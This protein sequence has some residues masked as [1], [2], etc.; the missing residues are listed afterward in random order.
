LTWGEHRMLGR[1]LVI[2]TMHHK[3]KVIGPVLTRELGVQV[4]VPRGFDTDRFGTFTREVPR[5][6]DQVSAARTKLSAALRVTG[7][8]LGIASEGS[9]A[10]HP[11]VA[12]IPMNTELLLLL[13]LAHGHE[14]RGWY[15]T[16]HTNMRAQEIATV[17]QALAFAER[18]GFPQHGVIVRRGPDDPV[19]IAKDVRETR[20]LRA[21][22]ANVLGRDPA[23]SAYIET[24]MRAHRNPTRQSAIRKA[25]DDL[26]NNLRSHCPAC[27]APGFSP[28]SVERGLPCSW[29]ATATHLPVAQHWTCRTCS[30]GLTRPVAEDDERADPQHCYRCNP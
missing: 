10:P 7:C 23:R 6:G 12:F 21:V 13:D 22:V 4:V 18:V 25:A 26:L 28:T 24:D 14:V 9:F 3:D 16:A 20:S 2:A 11:E 27:H 19:G 15:R 30:H 5:A 17:D 8:D 1:P 29:C